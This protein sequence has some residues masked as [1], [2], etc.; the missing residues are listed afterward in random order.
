MSL[1][2]YALVADGERGAL[3]GPRGDVAFLC[4][5]RW[6]DPALFSSLL[7]GRGHYAVTPASARYVWVRALRAAVA[8]LAQ[9]LGDNRRHHRVPRRARLS[10]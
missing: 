5:P 2:Q 4:C 7:G 8:D 9:P 3:I 1:R 6:Q 10:W